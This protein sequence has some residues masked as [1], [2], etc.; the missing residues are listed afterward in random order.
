MSTRKAC[1][2]TALQYYIILGG[3][4]LTTSAWQAEGL[5]IVDS[6][7]WQQPD[8]KRLSILGTMMHRRWILSWITIICAKQIGVASGDCSPEF[9]TC[10]MNRDCCDGLQCVTGDWA[11]TTDSTCLSER[12]IALDD[13]SKEEKFN[14]IQTFYAEKVPTDSVKSSEEAQRLVEKYSRSF[15]QLVSRLERRYIIAVTDDNTKTDEL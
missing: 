1:L 2:L 7:T 6:F 5:L 11:V 13:L 9:L 10:L 12:S 4:N 15:A 14:M 8:K 3:N